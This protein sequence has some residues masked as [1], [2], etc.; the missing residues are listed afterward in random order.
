MSYTIL[1]NGSPFGNFNTLR[2]LRQGNPLSPY[3]FILRAEVL[4]HMLTKAEDMGFMQAV[5]VTRGALSISHL[6][7]ADD[8]FI[9]CNAK[10]KEARKIN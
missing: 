8:V 5:R 1:L 6:F 9:F 3:L 4:S 7:F 10:V 2:G